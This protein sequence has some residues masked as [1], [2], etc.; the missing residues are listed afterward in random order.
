[1]VAWWGCKKGSGVEKRVGLEWDFVGRR[2]V[3][4]QEN[5]VEGKGVRGL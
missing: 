2:R 1:M 3:L 5:W 4:G